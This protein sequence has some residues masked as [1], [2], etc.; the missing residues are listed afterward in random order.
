MEMLK[1]L[2]LPI[3][4]EQNKA[5]A[6]LEKEYL[7]TEVIPLIKQELES[8][9]AQMKHSF[10]LD[11]DYQPQNGLE[12]RLKK[13]EPLDTNRQSAVNNENYRK[14]QYIIRVTFPEG[15]I[16]CEKMV[17]KTLLEVVRYAGA[18]NVKKLGIMLLGDNIISSE[19]SE[20][21]RYA[22]GQKEIEPGLYVNTYSDTNTKLEQ[23]KTINRELK[24]KLIVEKVMLSDNM[25]K[26]F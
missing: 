26:F 11:V 6:D 8:L 13:E 10:K 17:W 23:I 4:I 21:N 12:I 14:K 24:L 5:I 25:E 20:N 15:H 1:A 22:A 9:I 16:S 2:G 18:D 19:L 3:S 7:D